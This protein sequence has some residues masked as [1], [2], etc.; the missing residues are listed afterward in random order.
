MSLISVLL[1]VKIK[2]IDHLAELKRLAADGNYK[3]TGAKNGYFFIR[4]LINDSEKKSL[5]KDHIHSD[6]QKS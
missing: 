4:L 2:N 5:I 1:R 3:E 6:L